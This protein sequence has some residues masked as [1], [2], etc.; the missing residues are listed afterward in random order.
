MWFEPV[1]AELSDVPSKLKHQV[2]EIPP[3]RRSWS[4]EVSRSDHFNAQVSNPRYIS[5]DMS[6]KKIIPF[7]DVEDEFLYLIVKG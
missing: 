6:D 1:C 2:L 4:E 3:S 5:I 7:H